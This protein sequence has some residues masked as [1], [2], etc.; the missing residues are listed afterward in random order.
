MFVVAALAILH[1]AP[2]S[3]EVPYRA[4]QLAVSTNLVA[5]AYGSAGGVYVATS[6]NEG[7]DFSKPVKVAEVPILM[8]GRHRGP[9]I[10]ISKDTI[11]V[12]TVSGHAVATGPHAHGLPSD[13]DLLAW[14]STDRGK[15][16]SKALR[17]NDVPS[18]AR[19]GL[20][21]LA[22]DA[23]GNLFAAWLDLRH[24]GTR[25][26]G[27]WSKDS[28]ASWGANVQIYES[29]D[30]T[31][32]QCCHPFAAFAES[33]ALEVMWRNSLGGA[34]DLY[35]LRSGQG[36]RSFSKPE[37]LGNGTWMLN[38]CPM[39]GGGLAHADG[40][41]ITAWRRDQEIFLAEPGEPEKSI[42]EGKDVAIAASQGRIYA[43]WLQGTRLVAWN[44]GKT[45]VLTE[46]AALPALAALPTGGVLAAW[47]ENGGISLRR[48]R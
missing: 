14:R 39:D 4:P 34:R 18:A 45:E 38:A 20:H 36:E 10:V 28:G 46:K 43:L 16:W 8:L 29:P 48:L 6:T 21:T 44:Q 37:K 24:T 35:L 47:E 17:I 11:I 25:L 42:G 41:T 13:G 2:P 32:C 22:A 33:G 7:L 3:T 23:Q 15:T 26:F 9:R 31:I 19:E 40:R 12:T 1:M 5:L 27:A 30:G